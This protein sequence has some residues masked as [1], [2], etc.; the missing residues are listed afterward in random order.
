MHK[1]ENQ[2]EYPR[3]LVMNVQSQPKYL[4]GA[5]SMQMQ[6][7]SDDYIRIKREDQR[8][9]EGREG[10]KLDEAVRQRQERKLG[11]KNELRR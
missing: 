6:Y 1:D 2:D 7:I 8:I 9:R 5:P 4:Q 11:V 3:T 10:A